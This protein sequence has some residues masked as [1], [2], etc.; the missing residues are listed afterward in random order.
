[1]FL[2]Q[3]FQRADRAHVV[4]KL[5]LLT[6]FAQVIIRDPII[7]RR[8]RS[9]LLS[10][11]KFHLR[12][13]F[14]LH[15]LQ[16][17]CP[18]G[19]VPL[20]TV[21]QRPQNALAFRT[22]NRVNH[23]RIAEGDIIKAETVHREGASI[24]IDRIAGMQIIRKGRFLRRSLGMPG[25]RHRVIQRQVNGDFPHS[26]NPVMFRNAAFTGLKG[27]NI[28]FFSGGF[29]S[30]YRSY[31]GLHLLNEWIPGKRFRI[32]HFAVHNAVSCKLFADRVRINVIQRVCLIRLFLHIGRIR[33]FRHCFIVN[34][35]DRLIRK[36][37]NRHGQILAGQ[38]AAHLI[39]LLPFRVIQI[40]SA[41][42]QPAD[43]LF[44]SRPAQL[45]FLLK[46]PT[47]QP[48][49]LTVVVHEAGGAIQV[50]V[51]VPANAVFLFQEF[52]RS[53]GRRLTVIQGGNPKPA[54]CKAG[55]AP[56]DM[57]NLFVRNR[58]CRGLC[59][60]TGWCFQ[61]FRFLILSVDFFNLL[62]FSRKLKA[63]LDCFRLAIPQA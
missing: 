40:V 12:A 38:C 4:F 15:L 45:H 2:F 6:A 8:L 57:I 48:E 24:Q 19:Q 41:F 32:D 35:R 56:K 53:L 13:F 62:R 30:R 9:S 29:L 5:G 26:G 14:R 63:D 16:R 46:A 49:S 51:A 22:E 37:R 43:M 1:M 52:L 58:K 59:L 50:G 7:D 44:H 25:R 10:R 47:G 20:I 11:R 54:A 28:R 21:Q 18:E 34:R 3:C 61:Y 27:R 39:Q 42:D 33:R 31:I 17:F 60:C 55:T 23:F 36:A